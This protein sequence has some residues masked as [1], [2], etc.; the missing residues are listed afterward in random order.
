[1]TSTSNGLPEAPAGGL[2]A[3][4]LGEWRLSPALDRGE[5]VPVHGAVKQALILPLVLLIATIHSAH[6]ATI[7]F[8]GSEWAVRSGQGGPGPNAWDE[9]NVWLDDAGALHLRISQ[10]DG[11]WSCAEVTMQKR[12]GF[13]RYEFQIKGPIDRLD[14]NVVLGLFNYPTRDVGSGATHEIDI[15]FARWGEAKNP[16]G[17]YTV[18][19]V[20]KNLKQQSKSFP[21][22]L[23][24]SESTH[25]FTWNKSQIVFQSLRGIRTDEAGEFSRWVFSPPEAARS[26][27]QQPM[28]VH[29]NFWLFKGRE[30]KNSREMEIVVQRFNFTPE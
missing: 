23:E 16:M 17:N 21:F 25:R 20:E 19:P 27:S 4:I 30:P 24:S 10:K 6:G 18:W 22:T 14:D 15:E 11:K 2:T 28:P 29:I 26:I 7:K 1:M 12:L 13:G 3:R 5:N 8:S 9:K